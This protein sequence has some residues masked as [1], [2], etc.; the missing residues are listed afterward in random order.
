MVNILN[1]VMLQ[2]AVFI[3]LVVQPTHRF[4]LNGPDALLHSRQKATMR[5]YPAPLH[6]THIVRDFSR[7]CEEACTDR[8]I[9]RCFMRALQR[10]AE[11]EIDKS[12]IPE[13]IREWYDDSDDERDSEE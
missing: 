6:Q 12:L 13:A 11:G 1:R 9:Q 3:L 7:A 10:N 8:L 5:G 2:Y 4:D